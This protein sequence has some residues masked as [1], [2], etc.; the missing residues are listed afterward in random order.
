MSKIRIVIEFSD[1]VPMDIIEEKSDIIS[2]FLSGRNPFDNPYVFIE[3][4]IGKRWE[5][6]NN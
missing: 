3:E 4:Y 2:Q 1:N 6:V 5:P